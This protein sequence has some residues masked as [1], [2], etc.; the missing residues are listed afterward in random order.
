MEYIEF[1]YIIDRTHLDNMFRIAH[2]C[3]NQFPLELDTRRLLPYVQVY[4]GIF[5][6][7]LRTFDETKQHPR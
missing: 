1:I 7:T 5:Q 6:R 3:M 4:C 2:P